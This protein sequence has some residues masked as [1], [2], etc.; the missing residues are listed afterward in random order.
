MSL[1][2]AFTKCVPVSTP[3][4]VASGHEVVVAKVFLLVCSASI[5]SSIRA[6]TELKLSD[7]PNYGISRSELPHLPGSYWS[8]AHGYFWDDMEA[9]LR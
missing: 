1:D 4:F 5:G 3:V 2:V 6:R 9:C 8:V 7:V